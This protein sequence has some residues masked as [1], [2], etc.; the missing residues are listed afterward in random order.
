M[1]LNKIS[2][3][4]TTAFL[5]TVFIV[6]HANGY[7]EYMPNDLKPPPKGLLISDPDRILTRNHYNIINQILL[8]IEKIEIGVL[9]IN[10]MSSSFL[11]GYWNQDNAAQEFGKNVFDSW[12][13][14]DPKSNNGLLIFIATED[15]KMRIITGEGAQDYVSDDTADSI[16][17]EVKP[18]LK[19][20][21]YEKAIFVAIDRIKYYLDPPN[22][23]RR[24]WD[25]ICVFFPLV[26]ISM[27]IIVPLLIQQLKPI[28]KK[29]RDFTKNIEK[30]K[31]MQKSGKLNEN[32]VNSSCGICLEEFEKVET[33]NPKLAKYTILICGHNF[34][35]ECLESWL[36]KKNECP[37]CKM[38]DPT[39]SN[40]D[41]LDNDENQKFVR[42]N[43]SLYSNDL[44]STMVFIQRNRYP[45]FYNDYSFDFNNNNVSYRD[46]NE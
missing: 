20:K 24:L 34:H 6:S 2:C 31:K 18:F 23:F 1:Q 32:F 27:I 7:S 5:L 26:L 40:R 4:I 11:K 12:G 9:I 30:L 46:L 15:R 13:I 35:K 14:G 16:F 33:G 41:N 45:E 37:F 19:Q 10:K 43:H 3:S 21:E 28:N 39:N 25:G 8:K 42:E 44:L 17:Q 38:K 36:K 29:R 22:I